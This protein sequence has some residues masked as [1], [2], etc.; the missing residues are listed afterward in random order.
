MGIQMLVILY[1]PG[2]GPVDVKGH[3]FLYHSCFILRPFKYFQYQSSFSVD[4]PFT[5]FVYFLLLVLS[6]MFLFR[7]N[8]RFIGSCRNNILQYYLICVPYIQFPLMVTCCCITII[9]NV[10][11]TIHNHMRISPVLH[12]L[13]VCVPMQFYTILSCVNLCNYHHNQDTE[14]PT[15]QR[16]LVLSLC[17]YTILSSPRSYF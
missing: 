17:S 13:C 14:L 4:S 11:R 6:K 7:N 1:V 2:K 10:T 16:S 8:Y 9:S 12:A 3:L 5:Y 15:P